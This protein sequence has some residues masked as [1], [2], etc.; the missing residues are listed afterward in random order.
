M[1]R[2][3]P[4][5]QTDARAVAHEQRVGLD[6]AHFL[7]GALDRLVRLDEDGRVP[8]HVAHPRAEQ[9]AE[10]RRFLVARRRFELARDLAIEEGG[11]AVVVVDE[12]ED[13]VARREV[14]QRL[15]ARDERVR[16]RALDQGAAVE[17]I[18]G[19]A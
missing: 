9:R 19:A 11:E 4:V 15:L 5:R 17:T 18:A 10:A 8:R 3:M 7:A 16:S 13:E 1:A 2:C 12:A 14:A 6:R